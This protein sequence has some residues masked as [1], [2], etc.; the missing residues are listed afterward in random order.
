MNSSITSGL[1]F[2][3]HNYH[4]KIL[5][6]NFSKYIFLQDLSLK[7]FWLQKWMNSEKATECRNMIDYL[8]CL[9]QEG[10]LKYEYV[11]LNRQNTCC[12]D[13]N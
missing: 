4:S 12:N 1:Y 3:K 11:H 10:K 7:G 9:A 2:L 5:T 8:L 6:A 13:I